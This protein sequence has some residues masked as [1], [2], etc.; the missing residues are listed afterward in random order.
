M[1]I[2]NTFS[3]KLMFQLWILEKWKKINHKQQLSIC[4]NILKRIFKI[5][6]FLSMLCQTRLLSS[7]IRN[8]FELILVNN[9]RGDN[10]I[11]AVHVV[12]IYITAL[13]S[14]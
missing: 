11:S 5:H 12:T 10:S 1:V 3:G 13:T 8:T 7:H 2:I 6:P 9:P 14:L 4:S